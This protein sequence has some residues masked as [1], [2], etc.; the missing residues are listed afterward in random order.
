MPTKSVSLLN[1]NQAD[2]ADVSATSDI[3]PDDELRQMMLANSGFVKKTERCEMQQKSVG[4]N[5]TAND[6]QELEKLLFYH[7]HGGQE[8]VSYF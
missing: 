5:M 4:S 3:A 2:F 1:I 6:S 8:H 7:I